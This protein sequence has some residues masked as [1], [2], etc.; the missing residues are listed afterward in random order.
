MDSGL[1]ATERAYLLVKNEGMAFRDAY[2][3]VAKDL[4]SK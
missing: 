1:F 3:K 4:D 2:R